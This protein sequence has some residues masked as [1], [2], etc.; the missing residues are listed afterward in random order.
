MTQP[1]HLWSG[2]WARE[3]EDAADTLADRRQ[4]TRPVEPERV[5][6]PRPVAAG[7]APAPRRAAA[8][9]ASAAG[10][11][12]RPAAAERPRS[13]RVPPVRRASPR[14][15]GVAALLVL[16]LLAVTAV[17][18]AS[19]VFSDP[20]S[21]SATSALSPGPSPAP[22]QFQQPRPWVGLTTTSAPTGSGAL[23]TQ[24]V[25]GGPAD[26][27]GLQPGDVITAVNARPIA[28]PS[29]I[30]GAIDSQMVGSEVLFQV[31]RGGQLQTIGVTLEP[32]PAGS[33]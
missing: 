27:A 23:V 28:S 2:D 3:S 8:E 13:T 29:D 15:A 17:A 33:P 21:S 16:G 22:A 20:G 1:K 32:R 9:P 12:V 6:A 10:P 30:G 31:D 18:L 5:E 7:A 25:P 14:R 4:H 19:G 11:R 24:V 26:Q